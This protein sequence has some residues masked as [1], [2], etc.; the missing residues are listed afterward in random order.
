LLCRSILWD[1][2]RAPQL[3]NAEADARFWTGLHDANAESRDGF[4]GMAANAEASA[5]ALFKLAAS[6]AEAAA[7]A[8]DKAERLRRGEE[9]GATADRTARRPATPAHGGCHDRNP[10]H[11]APVGRFVGVH[12]ACHMG[13]TWQGLHRPGFV[14]PAVAQA[15][16]TARRVTP[17]VTPDVFSAATSGM[18]CG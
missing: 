10:P 7:E 18:I 16:A 1:E 2:Q 13:T 17:V 4:K 15:S 12:R 14:R 11:E 8:R 9:R 6:A 5:T 3:E